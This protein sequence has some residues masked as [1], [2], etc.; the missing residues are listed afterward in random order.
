MKKIISLS[1]IILT[2]V[3]IV[4]MLFSTGCTYLLPSPMPYGPRVTADGTG[5][6][7]VCL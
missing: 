7:I 3:L 4:A 1:S 5:G 6:A 2:A